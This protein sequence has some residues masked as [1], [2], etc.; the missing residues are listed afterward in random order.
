[1]QAALELRILARAGPARLSKLKVCLCVCVFE[2]VGVEVEAAGE[3]G[4]IERSW[5]RLLFLV[6]DL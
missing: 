4:V 1:M 3:E 2:G 6:M 5:L